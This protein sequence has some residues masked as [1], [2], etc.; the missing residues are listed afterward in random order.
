[1]TTWVLLQAKVNVN[2]QDNTGM[3]ALHIAAKTFNQSVNDND[4][5][6]ILLANGAKVNV[7]TKTLGQTPLHIAASEGSEDA[8]WL[9]LS[10][11]ADSSKLDVDNRTAL[12]WA[13]AGDHIK[14]AQL[15][16]WKP[17]ELINA[18]DHEKGTVLHY[19]ASQGNAGMVE[20]LIH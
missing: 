11:G 18:V 4:V 1:M 10:K 13:V 5:L 15:L 8:M 9:L 7:R 3:S 20:M 6:W 17:T 12:H 19:A 2:E 14:A 16:L